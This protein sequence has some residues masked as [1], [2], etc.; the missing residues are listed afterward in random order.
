MRQTVVLGVYALLFFSIIYTLSG[1]T[2]FENITGV[3]A[4]NVLSSS[5]SYFLIF[6]IMA[7]A[8]FLA[9]YFTFIRKRG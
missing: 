3:F 9:T 6:A 8:A 5:S 2:N 1:A 7:S 4:S